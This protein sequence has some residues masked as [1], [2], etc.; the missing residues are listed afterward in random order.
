MLSSPQKIKSCFK[1]RAH[2]DSAHFVLAHS[3]RRSVSAG[4]SFRKARLVNDPVHHLRM[5]KVE[6]YL[7]GGWKP[8]VH[9]TSRFNVLNVLLLLAMATPLVGL[10]FAWATF[11]KLPL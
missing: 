4:V 3:S 10:I 5:E 11:G 7:E 1:S 2:C 9:L 8:D 6:K